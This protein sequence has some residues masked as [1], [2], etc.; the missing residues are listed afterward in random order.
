MVR[1]L[2]PLADTFLQTQLPFTG[3]LTRRFTGFS[4]THARTAAAAAASVSAARRNP[5]VFVETG[6]CGNDPARTGWVGASN[7]AGRQ[8]GGCAPACKPRGGLE[9]VRRRTPVSSRMVV[10]REALVAN[11][12]LGGR[13]L[14][15]RVV[16]L[17][18]GPPWI[19]TGSGRADAM[20]YARG[21]A[22]ARAV[23]AETH[24][25]RWRGER[26]ASSDA[27]VPRIA[28]L[29][30]AR[31]LCSCSRIISYS[32]VRSGVTLPLA[33]IIFKSLRRCCASHVIHGTRTNICFD[34][35]VKC[36]SLARVP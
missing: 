30:L 34:Q 27:G 12:P 36:R 3:H 22:R 14:R 18:A 9:L 4:G 5:S 24:T 29:Q 2:L 21:M 35:H 11:S 6:F 25:D 15:I 7:Q 32:G 26:A 19:S 23:R 28:S 16:T 33:T 17:D 10:R 13:V 1:Q 31:C 20:R 8:A